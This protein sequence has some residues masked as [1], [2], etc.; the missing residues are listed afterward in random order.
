MFLLI[1]SAGTFAV[2]LGIFAHVSS[3]VRCRHLCFLCTTTNTRDEQSSAASILIRFFVGLHAL[4][5]L[6]FVASVV[7]EQQSNFLKNAPKSIADKIRNLRWRFQR[8]FMRRPNP[9][10]FPFAPGYTWTPPPAASIGSAGGSAIR[11]SRYPRPLQPTGPDLHDISLKTEPEDR[12]AGRSARLSNRNEDTV[13]RPS[14]MDLHTQFA[15]GN[16]QHREDEQ[17]IADTSEIAHMPAHRAAWFGSH[18]SHSASPGHFVLDVAAQSPSPT[19]TYPPQQDIREGTGSDVRTESSSSIHGRTASRE[20]SGSLD[21]RFMSAQVSLPLEHARRD[22][23]YARPLIASTSSARPRRTAVVADLEP[24]ERADF[25]HGGATEVDKPFAHV[26]A[27]SPTQMPLSFER[28]ST[29]LGTAA[30][31]VEDSHGGPLTSSFR[32]TLGRFTSSSN[33]ESDDE[34]VDLELESAT[35]IEEEPIP[36]SRNGVESDLS[37]MPSVA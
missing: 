31:D 36:D 12:S 20:S 26:P 27:C 21:T 33:D 32:L 29:S 6:F 18:D 35:K 28:T 10:L 14:R 17:S 23:E 5:I 3:Q 22:I 11:E 9:P 7:L 4:A 19:R 8:Q 37:D 25:D 1:V 2:G 13:C 16:V 30:S 24:N 15:A 34:V